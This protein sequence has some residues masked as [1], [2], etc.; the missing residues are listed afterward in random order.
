M[1]RSGSPGIPADPKKRVRHH[2]QPE[3][4]IV[5]DDLDFGFTRAELAFIK[6]TWQLGRPIDRIAGALRRPVDEVA[7]AIMDLCRRDIIRCRPGGVWGSDH[8][9]RSRETAGD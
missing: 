5:L 7:L 6:G 9:D 4:V 3:R 2:R 1:S 8:A